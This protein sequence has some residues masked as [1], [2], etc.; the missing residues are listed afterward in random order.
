MVGQ[1]REG[2][3]NVS[4][5]NPHFAGGGKRICPG[6][7]LAQLEL[8]LTIGNIVHCFT[9]E[10]P[11]PAKTVCLPGNLAGFNNRPQRSAMVFKPRKD[12]E[13]MVG[14]L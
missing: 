7:N 4:S 2:Q 3:R 13:Q 14:L 8:L 6:N 12:M 5:C 11:D 1:G 9:L 10:R